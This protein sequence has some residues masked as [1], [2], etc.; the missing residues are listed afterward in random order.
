M[1][2]KRL[3]YF[4]VIL[5]GCIPLNILVLNGYA[6]LNEN[7]TSTKTISL[8]QTLDKS[9]VDMAFSSDG[10]MIA[11]GHYDYSITIL[12]ASTNKLIKTI[13][14]PKIYWSLQ[15]NPVAFSPDGSVL[16]TGYEFKILLWNT[17]T[18]K[19]FKNLTLSD[20][21]VK[22][23]AFSSDGSKLIGVTEKLYSWDISKDYALVPFGLI[24]QCFQGAFTYDSSRIVTI[25]INGVEAMNA[26]VWNAST[27]ELITNYTEHTASIRALAVSKMENLVATSAWDNTTRVWNPVDGSTKNII[28]NHFDYPYMLAID[29]NDKYIAFLGHNNI[30]IYSLETNSTVG[31][32]TQIEG[33]FS[34]V[35]TIQFHP[36][37]EALYIANENGNFQVFTIPDLQEIKTFPFGNNNSTTKGTAID[38]LGIYLGLIMLGVL[39]TKKRKKK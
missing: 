34:A 2:L 12:D 31:N 24:C 19:N 38:T 28:K 26:H 7:N 17:T 11:L 18:W 6:S 30:E 8:N 32:I 16:A 39:Y 33:G 1:K 3:L 37:K 22:D 35:T 36:S 23:I 10:K 5:L 20:I 14:Y 4:L 21:D 9:I 13:G 27:L 25:G 29:N 15:Y